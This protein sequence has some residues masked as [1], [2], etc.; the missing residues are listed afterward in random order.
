MQSIT[1]LSTAGKFSNCG[2]LALLIYVSTGILY[3]AASPSKR[4]AK[5]LNYNG[6]QNGIKISGKQAHTTSTEFSLWSSVNR[7]KYT[8]AKQLRK[9]RYILDIPFR[10]NGNGKQWIQKQSFRF[11]PNYSNEVLNKPLDSK[12]GYPIQE[13]N[14]SP[15]DTKKNGYETLKDVGF[16]KQRIIKE[17][18]G[19]KIYKNTRPINIE[20]YK[21]FSTHPAPNS[22][23]ILFPLGFHGTTL[24]HEGESMTSPPPMMVPH[25]DIIHRKRR[26]SRGRSNVE[27]QYNPVIKRNRIIVNDKNNFHRTHQQKQLHKRDSSKK[28]E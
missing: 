3:I 10:K 5:T 6:T 2:K 7:S 22:K 4:Q 12:Q 27:K 9:N 23:S 11:V 26:H 14:Y 8:S 19:M 25:V 21:P 28:Y 1:R 15:L 18:K 13:S 16:H 17:N 20:T 24:Q